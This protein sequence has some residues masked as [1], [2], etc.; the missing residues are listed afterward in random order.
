MEVDRRLVKTTRS[1]NAI[2][3][4]HLPFPFN[5]C[6]ILKITTWFQYYTQTCSLHTY[7]YVLHISSSHVFKLNNMRVDTIRDYR[8]N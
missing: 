1:F 7:A 5:F 4:V 6:L 3:R 2:P 8:P